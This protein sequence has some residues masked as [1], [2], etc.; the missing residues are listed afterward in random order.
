MLLILE[1]NWFGFSGRMHVFLDCNFALCKHKKTNSNNYYAFY[2]SQFSTFVLPANVLIAEEGEKKD[3]VRWKKKQ[4]ASVMKLI[5]WWYP[6]I[7]ADNK[8]FLLYII[9]K[10]TYILLLNVII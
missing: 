2:V 3:V 8:S 4:R 9:I 5:S 7:I 1:E 6:P 10:N